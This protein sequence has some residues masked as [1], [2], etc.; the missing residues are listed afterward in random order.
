MIFNIIW[1]QAKVFMRNRQ[2]LFILLILPIILI[3]I[4][5]TSL[6][7]LFGDDG[8]AFQT[9][10]G[11]IEHESEE[12]QIDRVWKDLEN[13]AIPEAEQEQMKALLDEAY[14]IQQLRTLLTQFGDD[15]TL[16]ELTPDE[17][18]QA[19][20]EKEVS[21]V[22]EVP[23]NFTYEFAKGM[24]EQE[25]EL[26][27]IRFYENEGEEI[28]MSYIKG[29][30][31][32]FQEETTVIRYAMQHQLPLESKQDKTYGEIVQI[33]QGDPITSKE[34]Y[35]IGMAVMNVLYVATAIGSFAFLEK[36]LQVFNRIILSNVASYTYFI[37]IFISG[38][39]FSFIQLILLFTFSYLVYD[40]TWPDLFSFL[41]VT[42]TL[43]LAVGSISVLL[44]VGSYRLHS[45]TLVN[46]FGI[47]VVGILALLGGSFFPIGDMSYMMQKIGEFT[48]NGAG[49]TAYL[50]LL[51]GDGMMDVMGH[52]V[53]LLVLTIAILIVSMLLFPKRGDV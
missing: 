11:I 14:I 23:A 9:E 44:S 10:I 8:I 12:D 35:T 30:I 20:N 4:L 46:F 53:F 22:I 5:S 43:S 37:G 32:M 48:P 38:A 34:Y 3:V 40:V 47:I 6:G 18:Q 29:I 16:V 51:R 7:A 15:I 42:A 49:M 26:P 2:Q 19:L 39:L 27:S 13:S 24:L 36:R 25:S 21:A 45:E 33:S 41:I 17:K 31:E 28:A 1:K 52:L 50:S